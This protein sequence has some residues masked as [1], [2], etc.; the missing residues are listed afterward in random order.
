ML[1]LIIFLD[2]VNIGF[3]S[4]F[5]TAEVAEMEAFTAGACEAIICAVNLC[6]VKD[7]RACAFAETDLA[8]RVDWHSVE[9]FNLLVTELTLNHRT[10]LFPQK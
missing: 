4:T 8:C 10:V 3:I 1:V 5:G 9:V 6:P 7:T 2:P